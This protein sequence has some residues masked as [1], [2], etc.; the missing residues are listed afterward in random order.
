M[1][2]VAI[3]NNASEITHVTLFYAN[4]RRDP[5]LFIEALIGL[6]TDR[7]LETSAGL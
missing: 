1:A 3:N 5:N 2:Q 4:F 6:Q 7:A